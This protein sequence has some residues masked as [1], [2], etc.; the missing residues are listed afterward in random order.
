MTQFIGAQPIVSV[1]TLEQSKLEE[2]ARE[3]LMRRLIVGVHLSSGQLLLELDDGG[4]FVMNCEGGFT[5][6]S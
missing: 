4:R 1:Q 6:V 5:E 2:R 3:I